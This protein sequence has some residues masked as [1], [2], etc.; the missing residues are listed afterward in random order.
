MLSR[1]TVDGSNPVVNLSLQ[2]MHREMSC[3]YAGAWTTEYLPQ[4]A[5]SGVSTLMLIISFGEAMVIKRKT[6]RVSG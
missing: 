5:Q 6:N 1:A 4:L 3:Y 2:I